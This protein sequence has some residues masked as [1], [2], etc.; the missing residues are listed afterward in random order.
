[1]DTFI[2]P[3]SLSRLGGHSE[4]E[5][6]IVIGVVHL[7]PEWAFTIKLLMSSNFEVLE[8]TLSLEHSMG[9]GSTIRVDTNS[10]IHMQFRVREFDLATHTNIDILRIVYRME[11]LV[12]L[13][14]SLL[15]NLTGSVPACVC[16]LTSGSD[17]KLVS[18]DERILEEFIIE[19]KEV[20][21][22]HKFCHN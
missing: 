5:E 9:L 7:E 16:S 15:A 11:V 22:F 19:I 17:N 20:V 4:L 10:T 18:I 3:E 13:K 2:L 1:M 21:P 12:E 8:V 6:V 14:S